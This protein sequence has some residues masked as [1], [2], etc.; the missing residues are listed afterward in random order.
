MGC[1]CTHGIRTIAIVPRST[2]AVPLAEEAS[3]EVETTTT[4]AGGVEEATLMTAEEVGVAGVVI[5]ATALREA[6]EARAERGD[7][8]VRSSTTEAGV[9][10]WEREVAVGSMTT[11]EEGISRAAVAEEEEVAAG[12]GGLVPPVLPVGSTAWTVAEEA[13][14]RAGTDGSTTKG[15]EDTVLVEEG[16]PSEEWAISRHAMATEMGHVVTCPRPVPMV[17]ETHLA[18][19]R[20]ETDTW[21]YCEEEKTQREISLGISSG[22]TNPVTFQ[23]EM[24]RIEMGQPEIFL[25]KMNP[26]TFRTEMDRSGMVPGTFHQEMVQKGM[27]QEIFL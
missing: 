26:V 24:N 7:S 10:D 23:T 4:A 11:E 22:G 2:P 18:T 5:L 14:V 9:E 8:A 17:P 15:E 1:R 21:N 20:F 6:G 12:W 16:I 25:E 3:S 13:E 19:G 27:V